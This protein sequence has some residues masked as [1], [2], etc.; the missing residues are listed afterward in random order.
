LLGQCKLDPRW[1]PIRDPH[2]PD[3]VWSGRFRASR[4]RPPLLRFTAF[5]H[6]VWTASGE[7]D[8]ERQRPDASVSRGRPSPGSEHV[9]MV[10]I[11]QLQAASSF[12]TLPIRRA[13]ADRALAQGP[14]QP[15]ETKTVM[16]RRTEPFPLVSTS[17]LRL[18]L[19]VCTLKQFATRQADRRKRRRSLIRAPVSC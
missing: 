9:A 3:K 6:A 15:S 5:P 11:S 12:Q 14:L 13:S 8:A 18:I 4:L 10:P 16:L 2:H 1:L 7:C 17:I 19:S